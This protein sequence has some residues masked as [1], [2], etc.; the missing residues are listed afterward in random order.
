MHNE[1]YV[2]TEFNLYTVFVFAAFVHIKQGG[3]YYELRLFRDREENSKPE[4]G[5]GTQAGPGL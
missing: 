1:S 2:K 4:K 3:E 5:L